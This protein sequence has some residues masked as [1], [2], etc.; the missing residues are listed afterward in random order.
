MVL[1]F[2]NSH[3]EYYRHPF[4]A[5]PCNKKITIK[6]KIQSEKIPNHVEV[7][8]S[9]N[10]KQHHYPMILKEDNHNQYIYEGEVITSSFPCLMWYYF[11][12]MIDGKSLYYGNNN[13]M[14]G[15]IG[16][17]RYQIPSSYQVTVHENNLSTPQ[18]LKEAVMYQIFVDRFFNGNDDKSINNVKTNSLIHS[19]W[20]NSP[21]YIRDIEQGNVVRWDFF[22]GNL[23]GII[24]KLP[25][26]KELGINLIYLNPIFESSSN[27]KYDTADYKKVDSMFGS[28]ELFRELC[29]TAKKYGISI[30]LDGVFSHTGSDSIYFNKDGNYPSLGAYQSKASPYINWY[31][32]EDY[33]DKY[34]SWW[35]VE[36]LPNVNELEP[37]YQDFI[38]HDH[39]SVCKYWIRLGAKGW[40]LDVVDELPDEFLKMLRS[41][42]KGIDS[43]AVLIGEV[44]EDASNKLS[45]GQK[46]EYLFG[47]ELD[48][49]TNYPFRK[50]LLDFVLGSINASEVHSRLMSLFENYP[51][52][53]FY[54]TMNLIGSHDVART[55]TLVGEMPSEEN[56]SLENRYKLEL[57]P[58]QRNLAI[59]RMKMLSLFQ[60]TFPGMPCIY[61]GDE[62]GLEGYGDPLSRKTY[63][64]GNENKDLL[65]WYKNIISIRHEYDALKTGKWLSLI[66]DGDLYGYLR[67]IDKGIDVFNQAKKNNSLLVIFNRSKYTSHSINIDLSTI[68]HNK[69]II[70]LIASN[71][72][73]KTIEV[74]R[75]SIRLKIMPLEGKVLLLS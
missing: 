62:V 63:P 4:G 23:L 74:Q 70:D 55:L 69:T 57:S 20:E 35:G 34:D 54:S 52:H 30:I 53:H 59:A 65:D 68:P 25:Y 2:H 39:D 48:S 37:S 43:E 36:S 38:I 64:W 24:R 51:L 27:H 72:S 46:R 10:D 28:N 13:K 21:F 3:N 33:P 1:L 75:E 32:F 42:V 40:R 12:V 67:V 45:Y 31:R 41:A 7:L 17:V 16:E 73:N 6:L 66:K 29:T 15:G 22:G 47:N 9:I 56:L 44:W 49:V 58:D 14:L 71:S 19:H 26:L 5:V 50:T 18:W 61:Y 60:M 11:H 8:V